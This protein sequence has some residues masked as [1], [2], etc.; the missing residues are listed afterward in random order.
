MLWRRFAIRSWILGSFDLI[1]ESFESQGAMKHGFLSTA[2]S[3]CLGVGYDQLQFLLVFSD[4]RVRLQTPYPY[5]SLMKHLSR[6]RRLH[7]SVRTI[8][9]E[10]KYNLSGASS[11]ELRRS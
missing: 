8:L 11:T 4:H 10:I 7:I 5:I 2:C 6:L 3:N 1:R 9:K